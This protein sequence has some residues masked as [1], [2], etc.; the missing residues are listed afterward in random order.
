MIVGVQVLATNIP[1]GLKAVDCDGNETA[2]TDCQSSRQNLQD[3][4]LENA[5]DTTV[6]ACANSQPGALPSS[7]SLRYARRLLLLHSCDSSR[8]W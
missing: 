4:A 2:L 1:V 6:L 3:C 7:A 5:T 8:D